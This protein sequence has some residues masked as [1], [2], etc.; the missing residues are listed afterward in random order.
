MR[1][2]H[3]KSLPFTLLLFVACAEMPASAFYN[4][5]TGRWLSRDPI[6]EK[7]GI[8]LHASVGNSPLTFFD[9]DG[10]LSVSACQTAIDNGKRNNAKIRETIDQIKRRGCPD[11]DPTCYFCCAEGYGGYF[12]PANKSIVICANRAATGTGVI[13]SVAHELVHALDDC[14]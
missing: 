3:Q 8:N 14:K 11:P 9:A 1:I 6:G 10:R 4:P 5:N 2:F 7:T 13:E 12:S